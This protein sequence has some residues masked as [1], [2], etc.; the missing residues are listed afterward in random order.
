VRVELAAMELD[1]VAEGVLV[2]TARS[3]EE[4]LFLHAGGGSA[5]RL[6]V[7]RVQ[8]SELIASLRF[9][10]PCLVVLVGATASGKSHWAQEWFHPDQVVSS[11]RL[12]AMV[13]TGERDQRASRDAFEALEL[14]VGKRLRRRLTTVIDSTGLEV[15]RRDAWRGLAERHGVPAYAVVFDPP[16]AEVRRRNRAR[17]D[18]V[19][20]KVVTA[21]LRE[22]AEA[23]DKLVEE[24][25]AGVHRPAPVEL[26]PPAFLTALDAA[27]RQ[28]EDPMTL[29]FGLQVPRFGFPGH[30]AATAQALAD[31]ARAAEETGFT[32]LWVMDHF[33]QIPQVGREWEDMLESYTTLGYLAG[34][35]E[36]IRLGSLV[37]GIT[38]RNIAHLG[39]IVATLDVLSGGRAMC[40]IGAA[41]FEREHDL[42]GWEFPPLRER[43]DRLEDALELLPLLWGPGSPSF[44]GRTVTVS[45]AVCYP[46]PLQEKVPI[47]V[48]GSG[49]KRTLRLVAR[50]ADAC[51]LVGDV[52]RV[53]RKLAVLRQHCETEG[54]DPAAIEVTHLAQ[55]RVVPAADAREGPGAATV[56][57]HVGR[58]RELAEAGV[59][60]AIVGLSDV[61]GTEPV[62][63]FGEVIAAFRNPRG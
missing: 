23:F 44:E 42:Y 16:A 21:Q 49:E 62:R 6:E 29:E 59:E 54:R 31:V 33:L 12:R 18:P 53:R 58:Y 5:H 28:K 15:V 11:D 36:T 61:E 4:I 40:G 27:E 63:R 52:E 7:R 39:K 37:T 48:G 19:P 30:P 55:A 46:R 47:L 45:D 3:G 22:S 1:E 38:Y 2:A 34:V 10:D 20:T 14:I 41:W 57:E 9:P 56:E 13:G 17:G 32:S 25:F 60:R 8:G 43:F 24:G 26:V 50:H 51:N 35:T